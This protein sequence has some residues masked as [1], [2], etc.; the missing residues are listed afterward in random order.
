[1]PL[2]E[3]LDAD[4]RYFG[5][6]RIAPP[7]GWGLDW[8]TFSTLLLSIFFLKKTSL[9]QTMIIVLIE[10]YGTGYPL[11]WCSRAKSGCLR[12]WEVKKS[13]ASFQ[14]HDTGYDGLKGAS[15]PKGLWNVCRG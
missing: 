14:M 15:S 1:M 13:A 3:S 11:I 9:Y 4:R 8:L 12:G 5:G 2:G 6:H 7:G 10:E